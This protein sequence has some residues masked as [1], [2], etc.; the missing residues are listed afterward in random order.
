ML[1]DWNHDRSTPIHL[2]LFPGVLCCVLLLP[3]VSL[4]ASAGTAQ[5]GEVAVSYEVEV[6]ENFVQEPEPE[7]DEFLERVD[8]ESELL[9]DEEPNTYPTEETS[10]AA[11]SAE[12]QARSTSVC[13]GIPVNHPEVQLLRIAASDYD[14]GISTL[15]G[16][17]R[18][19]ARVISNKVL[20]QSGSILSGANAS[21]MV[22]QWGQFIDHDIDLTEPDG[23]VHEFTPGESLV[24][25]K[26]YTGTWE[27]QGRYR[28]LAIISQQRSD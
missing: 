8:A 24:V 5:S 17:S 12:K 21:D 23:T 6:N 9:P 28:E 1:R 19:S 20:A 2:R 11:P 15:A 27:Q 25:P 4:P 16:A 13:S 7:A 14:D 18:D 3:V 26:G 22:W 10:F